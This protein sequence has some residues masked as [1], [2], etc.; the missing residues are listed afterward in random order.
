MIETVPMGKTIKVFGEEI[1]I[2]PQFCTN[3]G[4]CVQCVIEGKIRCLPYFHNYKA[5]RKK[6]PTAVK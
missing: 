4:H 2:W 1:D 6:R 5:P 3:N